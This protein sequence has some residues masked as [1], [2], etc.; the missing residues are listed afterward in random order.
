MKPNTIIF[1]FGQSPDQKVNYFADKDGKFH[2]EQLDQVFGECG[3]D[4]A[5]ASHKHIE[6]M[7]T[8]ADMIK[9]E[10][11]VCIARNFHNLVTKDKQFIDIWLVEFFDKPNFVISDP[12]SSFSMQLGTILTMTKDWKQFQLRVFV[13]IMDEED[14]S[15]IVREIDRI[16]KELRIPAIV[17]TVNFQRIHSIV[18]VNCRNFEIIG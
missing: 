6:L 12:A 7:K 15:V 13:R 9:L 10:K 18:E 11:N 8:V 4:L 14:R 16:L 17:I 1:G 5:D 3:K 2:N